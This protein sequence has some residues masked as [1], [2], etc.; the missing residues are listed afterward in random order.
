MKETIS[1]LDLILLKPSGEKL[2][3]SIEIKRPYEIK[4]GKGADFARCPVSMRGLHEN[5]SDIAGE[6]TFQALT[7]AIAFVRTMLKH[8]IDDGGK[9]YLNDGKSEFDFGPYFPE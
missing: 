9:I 6:N 1:H 3:V 7:L 2:P 8:F 4:D 5:L